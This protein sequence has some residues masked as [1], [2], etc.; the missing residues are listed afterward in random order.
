MKS[1][2][3]RY[4]RERPFGG[5]SLLFADK[6]LDYDVMIGMSLKHILNQEALKINEKRDDFFAERI[7]ISA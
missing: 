3:N 5:A 2:K 6:M 7:R 1:R 4:L